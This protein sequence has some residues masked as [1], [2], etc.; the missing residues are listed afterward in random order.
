MKKSLVFIG[1]IVSGIFLTL[2]A[3]WIIGANSSTNDITLFKS[4]GDCISTRDFRVFQVLD[5]GNALADE[6]YTGLVV[7]FFAEKDNAYYD[8]QIINIPYGKCARQIGVFKYTTQENIE[9]TVPIVAI[10][11]K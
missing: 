3:L 5:D 10:R 11:N 6:E 4:E 1:G 2:I 8:D 9:K 7:L